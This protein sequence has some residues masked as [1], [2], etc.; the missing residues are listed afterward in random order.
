MVLTNQTITDIKMEYDVVG[1]GNIL[2]DFIVEVDDWF[3]AELQLEKGKTHLVDEEKG[4]EILEKIKGRKIKIHAGGSAANTLSG[5]ARLGNK[6]LL[7]GKVGNDEHGK[8][9]EEITSKESTIPK[10]SRHETTG[11]AITFITPDKER[12]FATYLG[13][14]LH[15]R[16]EDILE[17]EIKKGKIFH[18]EGYVLEEPLLRE[19]VLHAIKIAKENN[20]KISLDLSDANLILRNLEVLK[21]I[22]KEHADIIFVNE[23]EAFALTNLKAEEALNK[24]CDDYN[25]EIAVVKLGEKGSLIK[26]KDKIYKIPI[27]KVD[28]INT[29]GAGD[30]YAAGFLHGIV[31][32]LNIKTSGK[33][34]S[35]V[36]SKVVEKE[37]ARLL[38]EI[39]DIEKLFD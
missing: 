12:T 25:C 15:L 16:K 32:G 20:T 26:H 10:L 22:V 34:A 17:D 28:V 1:I 18:T 6:T 7:I 21:D 33:I 31:N 29:N 8:I 38:E 27:N 39:K 19:A 11:F 4:K 9:Y 35:Y 23:D 2:L 30:A 3:L 36:A 37:E 14:S 5:L 24:I 13:S